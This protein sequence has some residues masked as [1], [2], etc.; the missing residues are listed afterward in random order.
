L[1]LALARAWRTAEARA[2]E[3]RA[4]AIYRGT[5]D[6]AAIGRALLRIGS[7]Y[8]YRGSNVEARPY[9]EQARQIGDE[10]GDAW[11]RAAAR[12][13][14]AFCAFTRGDPSEAQRL[15]GEMLTL[16]RENGDRRIEATA[17]ANLGD[18]AYLLGALQPA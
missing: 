3:R 7:V 11:L 5:G 4:L 16:S 9:Y 1:G 13:N 15:L 8:V 2:E 12:N 14:L 6:R 10:L 18:A 17:L